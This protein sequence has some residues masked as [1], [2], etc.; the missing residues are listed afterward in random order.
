MC[1]RKSFWVKKRKIKV[2]ELFVFESIQKGLRQE[3]MHN[4][5]TTQNVTILAT[6]STITNL[7]KSTLFSLD[8]L[9]VLEVNWTVFG[10]LCW[11]GTS[12]FQKR[13]TTVRVSASSKS[14]D[15]GSWKPVEWTLMNSY[16]GFTSRC[17]WSLCRGR[18]VLPE[19][20]FVFDEWKA[21]MLLTTVCYLWWQ[22]VILVA[23]G[24][25]FTHGL[26]EELDW[27]RHRLEFTSCSQDN[28]LAVFLA[29]KSDSQEHFYSI[30]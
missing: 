3:R 2:L 30:S 5:Q 7:T 28:Q 16:S 10:H 20:P 23:M 13:A 21:R 12:A 14:V 4:N 26:S 29:W 15:C 24:S 19:P 11:F 1:H 6:K 18:Q 25:N 17:L 22:G 8:Y 27:E 9:S